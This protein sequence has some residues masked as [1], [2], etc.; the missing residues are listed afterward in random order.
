MTDMTNK[1]YSARRQRARIFKTLC[2]TVKTMGRAG[3]DER[4]L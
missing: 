2:D 4:Q 3:I 1:R